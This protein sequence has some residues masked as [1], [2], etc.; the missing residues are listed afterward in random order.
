MGLLTS[1]A[2][3]SRNS[4]EANELRKNP[5]FNAGDFVVFQDSIGVSFCSDP[6]LTRD[7]EEFKKN[8]TN[9]VRIVSVNCASYTIL[10]TQIFLQEG[11]IHSLARFDSPGSN[12]LLTAKVEFFI[13]SKKALTKKIVS[14]F[15][16][17]K[18][19]RLATEEEIELFKKTTTFLTEEV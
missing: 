18:Q 14:F 5:R 13:G 1:I 10:T 3:F 16:L 11:S 8:T 19:G 17:N 9:V 7:I 15:E 2:E 12:H 4:K 6:N